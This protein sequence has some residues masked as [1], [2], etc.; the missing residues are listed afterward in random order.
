MRCNAAGCN[1]EKQYHCV[2]NLNFQVWGTNF[3]GEIILMWGKNVGGRPDDAP[4][5]QNCSNIAPRC[6]TSPHVAPRCPTLHHVAP[7]CP[8]LH[9]VAPRCPTCPTCPSPTK[10]FSLRCPTPHQNIFPTYG[11]QRAMGWTME[12]TQRHMDAASQVI[13][14]ASGHQI[15]RAGTRRAY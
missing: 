9:H 10:T 11:L 4:N 7:R 6:P 5:T 1:L 12:R 14:G 8:T 13:K 3:S 15:Q 2:D